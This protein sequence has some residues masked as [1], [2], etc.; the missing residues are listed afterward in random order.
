ML[1]DPLL[2]ERYLRHLD[3]LIELSE[4]E[5]TGPVS[6]RNSTASH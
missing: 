6:C 2:Q 3:K 1:Q 5:L 4:K